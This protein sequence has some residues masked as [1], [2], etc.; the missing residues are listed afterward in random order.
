[1]KELITSTWQ[2]RSQDL[3]EGGAK[4]FAR[5][6][7]SHIPKMFTTPLIKRVLEGTYLADKEGCFRPNRD[8]KLLL[9]ERI[10]EASKFIIGSSF[11]S[12]IIS[13]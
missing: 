11:Q 8:E 5:K 4:I 2:W 13:S 6:L 7:F 1:M 9:W 12:S 3:R 10:L